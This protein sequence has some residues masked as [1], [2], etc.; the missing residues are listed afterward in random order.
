MKPVP[1][2][3]VR[4]DYLQEDGSIL[5][6]MRSPVKRVRLILEFLL[7]ACTSLFVVMKFASIFQGQ[8]WLWL[9]PLPSVLILTLTAM[10]AL[11]LHEVRLTPK[12]RGL[13]LVK[14]LFFLRAKYDGQYPEDI[15][16]ELNRNEHPWFANWRY[17]YGSA[18][19]S[20]ESEGWSAEV[21]VSPSPP[22]V[23]PERMST[24]DEDRVVAFA[25][26]FGSLTQ[27]PVHDLLSSSKARRLYTPTVPSEPD[28][29]Q[30]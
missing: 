4:F 3:D 6:D 14:G 8:P 27:I 7:M 29:L 10:E 26:W 13:T 20:S 30:P 9:L 17:R 21:Y 24:E 2:A 15:V 16:L 28:T 25:E 1:A 23:W 19:L 12:D 18:T 11:S 22:W 5:I